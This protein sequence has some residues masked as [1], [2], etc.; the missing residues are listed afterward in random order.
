MRFLAD[1]TAIPPPLRQTWNPYGLQESP[2]DSGKS[3]WEHIIPKGLKRLAGGCSAGGGAP[4]GKPVRLT[5]RAPEAAPGSFGN[6][7][8]PSGVRRV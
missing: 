7:R 5:G 6:F 3:R 2:R 1:W 8:H 4:T